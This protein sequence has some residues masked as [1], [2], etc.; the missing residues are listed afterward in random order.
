MTK[1]LYF[2]VMAFISIVALAACSVTE[3]NH[4][5]TGNEGY[6]EDILE[7]IPSEYSSEQNDT[8]DIIQDSMMDQTWEEAYKAILCDIDSNL[9]DP[10]GWEPDSNGDVYLGI[11]DFNGDNVPELIIGNLITVAV[12]TYENGNA[13]KIADL[14]ELEE[15]GGINGLY[16][17]DNHLI[18]VNNG[19]GGSCYVCFTYD[20]EK[21]VTGIYD[22][23]NPDKGLINGQQVTGEE[24]KQQFNLSELTNGSCIEYSKV[25]E[26]DG[27]NLAINDI[28]TKMDHI[29][30]QLLELKSESVAE[31]NTENNEET[32]ESG[33]QLPSAQVSEEVQN[34][35][36]KMED[37]C[38]AYFSGDIEGVKEFLTDTYSWDIDVY[39]NPGEVKE[40]ETKELTGLDGISELSESEEYWLS[41]PFVAPGEDSRTYLSVGFIYENGEW[42]VT[43]Y[44][45]EK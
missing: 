28:S 11:H 1:K 42:K 45:L 9:I 16:Y 40:M 30:F 4:V 7:E 10:Y 25:Y 43:F 37:F 36:Q 3:E 6:N 18:L 2:I 22:E 24:Y 35:R 39:E 38:Q 33:G 32:K 27:V 26:Q 19:S 29:D 41:Q 31:S 23:Y 5:S 8:S 44:G 17:K 20:G 13:I 34:L 14:Y 12:Y 15:W 21:Y